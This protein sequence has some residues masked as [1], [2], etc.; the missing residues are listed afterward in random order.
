MKALLFILFL[1]KCFPDSHAEKKIQEFF[2]A[3]VETSWDYL[4]AGGVDPAANQRGSNIQK[5]V[6][7]VY[8]EF[9]DSTFTT[10]KTKPPWAGIQGPTIRAEVNDRVVVHFKNFASYPLSISP[11]GIPYW[12][13]SE[14]AGYEDSTSV[15]EQEDDAVQPGGYYK[16][17]WDILPNS[18]PTVTDPECL[19]YSYSS[20][21]DSVRDFNSGLIG[22]FLICKSGALT[23]DRQR[24]VPEFVL[25]FA[26][27][28]ESKSWY[29]DVGRADKLR[30]SSDRQQFHT[31]NGYVNSTL[32]GL[33]LCQK[34]P[35]VSWHLIG[36]G[37]TPDIHTIQFQDHTLKVMDHRRI[38]VEIT[39]MTFTTAL[40]KPYT[41]GK[42]L[43]SCRIHSHRQAGM[44][45]FFTVENCPESNE[46][47]EKQNVQHTYDEDE[48]GDEDDPVDNLFSIVFQRHGPPSVLRSGGRRP[49]VWIHY[50]SAE[51]I[52][53][54]YNP[55]GDR[56]S[57]FEPSVQQTQVLGKV[58][59]KVAYVEYT[60]STFTKKKS[61][62]NAL[63]GPELRGEVNDQFQIVFK[64]MASRP[65][66][67]FPNGLASVQPVKKREKQVD[68]RSLAVPPGEI[69]MYLWK[70][71]AEDAPTEAD[72]R[73]LTR[74]YHSTLDP[75]RDIASGLVGPLI[76]CKSES[77]DKRG[78]VLSSDREKH[79][80]FSIFDEN[81][82]WYADENIR[83]FSEDHSKIDRNDPHFYNSNIMHSVNGFMYNSLQFSMCVGDVMLWHVANVGMQSDF[84]SVY[85]TG[86]PFERDRTYGTVLTLFPMI[87]DTVITEMETEGEWEIG[88]F[89]P[90]LKAQGMSV[91][92]SVFNCEREFPLVDTDDD[93]DDLEDHIDK[94][95]SILRSFRKRNRTVAIQV[96]QKVSSNTTQTEQQNATK[97]PLEKKGEKTILVCKRKFVPVDE[98]EDLD[99]L[100]Q[101]GIPQDIL[102][103]LNMEM[104]SSKRQKRL[105]FVENDTEAKSDHPPSRSHDTESKSQRGKK[106]DSM[107]KMGDNKTVRYQDVD[108][109]E[110]SN[111][112]VDLFKKFIQKSGLNTTSD[113]GPKAN[114]TERTQ[115]ERQ[116][117]NREEATKAN[118]AM[119]DNDVLKD[120]VVE[121]DKLMESLDPHKYAYKDVQHLDLSSQHSPSSSS[122]NETHL[123]NL[124]PLEYDDYEDEGNKS[125]LSV[126]S[127]NEIDIRSGDS[128]FRSYY[129]AAE[130][131]MW[132]YGIDK[133]SH[134]ISARETKRGMRKYFPA[135][136]KV[137]YRAYHDRDFKKPVKRGELDE[138]LGIMG[139]VLKVEVNDVLTVVFKN[140]AS[141]PYSLHL[142]GVYDRTMASS[143]PQGVELR[144]DEGPGDPVPPG[145]ERIY[146]WRITKR[147]GPS[148][149]DFDCKAGAYYSTVN[150]E[151]DINSGLI[152]PLLICRPGTLKP[153][154]LLQQGVQD[155]FLLFTIFD[156]KKSWYLED[157]IRQFCK[158]PCQA[159][160]DD[161]WFETNN[162][163]AAINGY[164]ADTLPGLVVA[165]H[166]TSR[167][168]L[169]N[170]GSVGE[171]HAVHFHGIPFSI[172]KDQEHRL[173]I[174]NLYPGVFGSIEMRP[175]VVGTW[176][177]ECT[178][179]DHQRSGMR[180]KLL[181]YNAQCIQPLGM[182]S[183]WIADE[184]LTESDHYGDWKAGLARLH[185]SGSVNAWVG[186]N[187]NSWIQVD[188]LRPMVVHG[189]QTQGAK[190]SFGLKD[191]FTMI[192]TISYSLDQKTWKMY[193]G[194]SS[195]SEYKFNGNLDGSRVN[196]NIFSPPIIGRYIRIHPSTHVIKPTLRFELLGCDL[197]SC[198]LPLGMQRRHPEIQ[199][200][201]STFR[202]S[203]RNSWIPDLARLNQDGSANAWRPKSNNPYEWLQVDFMNVK[204]VTGIVTQGAKSL[205]TSM[206]VTEFLISVSDDGH[207]W[208]MV[209]EPGTQREKIFEGNSDH[210]EQKLNVFEP[211]LFTRFIR[212]HPK[213]WVNDIALRVEFLGCDTQQRL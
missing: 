206:M 98:A 145:E 173:G 8:T 211:P 201:A 157:N 45:A 71:T 75:E 52:M 3:A 77:L 122:Q 5:Y 100:S 111:P 115:R 199:I 126:D 36:L 117:K 48:E 74:L 1:V 79:L 118:D 150:M 139:P 11:I 209:T 195:E 57:K 200:S 167:W 23:E 144:D 2:I 29:R 154:V 163:F 120:S 205:F 58:Y 46:L 121:L 146:S 9:T 204:R 38:T 185:L 18:G 82:S 156:E 25:L 186:N 141:R 22:A 4:N 12:K 21:V 34:S 129:I 190:T 86:N 54:D 132:D 198:S 94:H 189:I 50:I 40:L 113:L 133:P 90:T 202:Q 171:F 208:A 112:S 35:E 39:P 178:I 33:K 104:S 68:L 96:C 10:P 102:D 108:K 125:I 24:K 170:V 169:L 61:Q 92:Y 172:G 76:I 91:R 43:I 41:E 69:M 44:S 97:M 64:N 62:S 72:P 87:G 28:D 165:Q 99:V 78:K 152:G 83:K 42:F 155:L 164:V 138:H 140:T 114:L 55:Q 103:E 134:L 148:S 31:I 203:W 47:P 160:V 196:D 30:K 119:S 177:V 130:E 14:G 192:F 19:T 142:H 124:P 166:Q 161:P 184:Q 193:K 135:Y 123:K 32:K 105:A 176:L 127:T 207:S 37:S 6:K 85:F 147:Q 95:F 56:L 59:K 110:K 81:K 162:K 89:D 183:G 116:E 136:K 187:E 70:V 137:V 13:Q 131:I 180:A 174:F 191:M 17:I 27:F 67:I 149:K 53:W 65:Y 175:G 143:A 101:G 15:Q 210:D 107:V 212:I 159:K 106:V 213:G 66:N 26:V 194:N 109:P 128:K 84:L 60:D 168:H 80:M 63:I 181:V 151:K 182:Q 93:D 158:P 188:L 197:N 73:C 153:R 179:G 16:Y 49:K 51:E 20:Q 7:A 88:A